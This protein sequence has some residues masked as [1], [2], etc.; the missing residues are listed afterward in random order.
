MYLILF[1]M[2]IEHLNT[3]QIYFKAFKH[4]TELE[5]ALNYINKENSIYTHI[6]ILGKITQFYIDK[7]IKV[8]KDTTYIKKFWNRIWGNGIDF[9]SFYSPQIGTIFIAGSLASTFLHKINGKPLAALSSGSYGIF[10]GIGAS[11]TEATHYL[12][13]LNTGNY[14]LIF[15]GHE[16]E[17]LH[18]E[19]LLN[20]TVN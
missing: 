3:K 18:L 8:S 16:G 7:D 1:K 4:L 20:N 12:K 17:L 14:I 2:T 13:L 10:R 6:S 11:D 15:R 19:T 5:S 9:G